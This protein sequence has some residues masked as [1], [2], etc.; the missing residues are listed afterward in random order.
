MTATVKTAKAP[1]NFPSIELIET[2]F[3]KMS[4][5]IRFLRSLQEVENRG[6]IA[7]FLGI[8][9][10][11]VR[12]VLLTPVKIQEVHVEEDHEGYDPIL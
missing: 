11:W 1:S 6:E 5:R 8:R 4:Q 7:K 3:P 9:Y 12:N 2:R 10:Q